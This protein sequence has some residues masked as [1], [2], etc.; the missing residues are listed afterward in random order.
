MDGVLLFSLHRC[1][2]ITTF[3]CQPMGDFAQI[4][5]PCLASNSTNQ[6]IRSAALECK[7]AICMVGLVDLR[8][9]HSANIQATKR[10]FTAYPAL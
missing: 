4:L 1:A 3:F 10:Y 2:V 8:A 6:T 9:Q 5:A 7:V